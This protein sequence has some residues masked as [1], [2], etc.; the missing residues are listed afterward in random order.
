MIAML[1]WLPCCHG[2]FPSV[3]LRSAIAMHAEEQLTLTVSPMPPIHTT[4]APGPSI[5]RRPQGSL[6]GTVAEAPSFFE[7]EQLMQRLTEFED[8]LDAQEWVWA[9]TPWQQTRLAQQDTMCAHKALWSTLWLEGFDNKEIT[10]LPVYYGEQD[11]AGPSTPAK[12]MGNIE[13][14]ISATLQAMGEA[15][16]VVQELAHAR[17][18]QGKDE[19]RWIRFYNLLS[20][21]AW[22][23]L[24]TLPVDHP[25]RETLS[26]DLTEF[27]L[28]HEGIC[29]QVVMGGLKMG[30]SN[31]WITYPMI[32]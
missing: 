15:R 7:G 24:K 21:R 17:P 28:L 29:G 18:E 26:G 1:S 13:K 6:D 20:K 30:L 12:K 2:R 10:D 11:G 31:Y 25:K 27:D 19:A 23:V 14:K 9:L 5:V 3:R 22:D 4:N 8:P 16:D 32:G